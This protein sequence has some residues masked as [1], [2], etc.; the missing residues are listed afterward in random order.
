MGNL[1]AIIRR[2]TAIIGHLSEWRCGLARNL[3][4][5]RKQQLI[6]PLR[7]PVYGSD[8]REQREVCVF[9]SLSDRG[10]PVSASHLITH[11]SDA[12]QPLQISLAS[13]TS[14]N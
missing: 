14:L 11:N 13:F 12:V 3:K 5:R 8:C 9:L 7:V 10:C 6:V 2:T 1:K 4:K